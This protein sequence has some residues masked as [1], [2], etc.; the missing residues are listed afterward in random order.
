MSLV[1]VAVPSPQE[2]PCLVTQIYIDL[3]R[4]RPTPS[5][6]LQHNYPPTSSIVLTIKTKVLTLQY[7]SPSSVSLTLPVYKKLIL[8]YSAISLCAA[9]RLASPS[10]ASATNVTAN[11]QSAIVTFA[12]Q[13]SSESATNAPSATTRTSVS[14]AAARYVDFLTHPIKRLLTCVVGYL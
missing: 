3:K 2:E 1:F 11:V 12:Q 7:V 13:L 5:P 6:L 4:A 14:C 8:T 10:D 9:N